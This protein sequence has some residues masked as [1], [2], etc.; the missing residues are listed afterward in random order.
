[1]VTDEFHPVV[2]GL[3]GALIGIGYAF[4][5]NWLGLLLGFGKS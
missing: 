1:M 4:A 5:K 3:F 2:G